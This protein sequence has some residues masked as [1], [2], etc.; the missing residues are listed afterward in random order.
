MTQ[1]TVISPLGR[2]L[3]LP[4]PKRRRLAAAAAAASCSGSSGLA[5]VRVCTNRTCRKQGSFQTLE[6]LSALAPPGVAV[7]ACGCLGRCGSGPNLA[8]LPEGVIVSHCGTAARAARVFCDAEDDVLRSLEALALRKRAESELERGN[9]SDAEVLLTRA[10]AIRPYGGI[11]VMYKDR[12]VARLGM[13]NYSG[14]LE[15]A[16]KASTLAP[17]YTEAYLCQG[18]ALMAM[19]QFDEAEKF[20]STTLRIDP[21]IRRSRSFKDRVERLQQKLAAADIS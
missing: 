1:L 11:H 9:F 17:Q 15:D 16:K 13:G 14:S 18:D 7:R 20:Y 21:S 3:S 5:E 8:L 19:E 4:H 12:S 2:S 6:A 10:I